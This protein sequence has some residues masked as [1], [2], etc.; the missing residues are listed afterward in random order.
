MNKL[1][2][3][4]EGMRIAWESLRENRIRAGLTI[5]G[6][7]IGVAV[8]VT[9]AALIT[10][11]RSSVLESFEAAGPQNFIVTPFDFSA[12][13]LVGG[14]SG[15]PPW[16]G[17][18]E[19]T[20]DEIEA[21]SRLPGVREAVADFDFNATVDA[22][23]GIRATGVQMGAN[24]AGWPAYIVGE[25]RAGRNFTPAEDEGG[26]PVVVISTG[27][28]ETL[29]GSGDPIGR[30]VRISVGSRAVNQRFTVVGVF[31]VE[32]NI[33]VNSAT[34]FAIV[35]HRSAIRRLKALNPFA[36]TSILVV[37]RTGFSREEVQDQVIAELRG[38][39]GLLPTE[40][41]DFAV[42]RSDQLADLFNRLTGVF[43]LV[44]I[45][46]SSVG[47]LVGGV[48]VIGIMLISV[49]ERTREIG[50]RKALGA[51]RAEILWQFLV[52]ASGLTLVGGAAGMLLGAGAAFA[53]ARF[54][55]IPAAIPL[56]SVAA[57]LGTAILTGLLFGLLPAMRAARMEPVAALRFE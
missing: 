24:S 41:N 14:G 45:A 55:P 53:V 12:V 16:W 21:V 35:P 51:T 30:N 44:M 57:A 34:E 56:W 10:G 3:L 4:R 13:R 33:F 54:T 19:I 11:I 1:A 2:M 29:F 32:G 6:V 18:P 25:F 40:E 38:S 17:K 31:E 27:L 22:G 39:R 49:T 50:I 47:L 48:G 52:E 26:R 15:R 28:A 36:F 20:E 5:L 37:P 23:R 43:F 7:A 46:L 8:V 9:M 42:V